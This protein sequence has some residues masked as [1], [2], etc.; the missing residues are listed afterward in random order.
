MSAF[1][2][3]PYAL[4]AQRNDGEVSHPHPSGN[5]VIAHSDLSIHHLSGGGS[6]LLR[7]VS[8]PPPVRTSR[9]SLT[10]LTRE[11]LMTVCG[12]LSATAAG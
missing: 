7:P 8:I 6:A 10:L 3:R 9:L 11:P 1:L 2:R 12:C 5:R 4:A